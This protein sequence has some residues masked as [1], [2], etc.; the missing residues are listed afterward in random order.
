MCLPPIQHQ[1]I[2]TYSEV[3]AL[4]DEPKVLGISLEEA[5]A[6]ISKWAPYQ[7]YYCSAICR[8]L[9]PYQDFANV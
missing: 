1:E 3:H 6:E 9:H 2:G 4:R 5:C 7:G 8:A